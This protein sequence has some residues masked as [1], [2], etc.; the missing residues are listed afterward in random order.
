MYGD[1]LAWLVRKELGIA[2]SDLKKHD[3]AY[4][5]R[6]KAF[7]RYFPEATLVNTVLGFVRTMGIDPTASGA[8]TLDIDPRPKKS[9][10]AFCS[11][12][13]IPNEIYLVIMPVGGADDY[14]AFLHELGHA[15]HFGYTHPKLDWEYKRLGDNSVT[16][17]YAIG[18]D[19]L[20]QDKIWLKKVM[21][22]SD[23]DVILRHS[24]LMELM[25]LRRYSAK[26]AY[27][28]ILHGGGPLDG[29]QET[30][31]QLLTSATM[32][33]YSSTQYLAD[34]DAFFYCARYLRAWMVQ[35]MLHQHL[36]ENFDE[37]WFLNPKSGEFLKELWSQ[38]QKQTAEEL[39][40]QLAYPMLT[41]EF[42]KESIEE[43]LAR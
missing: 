21:R 25:M 41:M 24:K 38:G 4:L 33:E 43:V 3:L 12:V 13:E 9:P 1:M 20:M 29:K 15:L 17:G 34:V 22:L 27:E 39:A 23:P 11:T 28:L 40:R 16:E 36:R 35:G 19:H 18:F 6:A 42:L 2:M 14:E 37:D 32:A 31:T 8:I 7:D 10:R 26:L 5:S 30:Y